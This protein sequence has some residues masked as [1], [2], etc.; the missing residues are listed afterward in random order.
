MDAGL[1]LHTCVR[2]DEKEDADREEKDGL[3]KEI[4]C[5]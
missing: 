2:E 1:Q 5:A 4:R 3:R